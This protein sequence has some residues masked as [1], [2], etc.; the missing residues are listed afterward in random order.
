MQC[1]RSAMQCCCNALPRAAI[2]RITADFFRVMAI[3]TSPDFIDRQ[4]RV[5][6]GKLAWI[7]PISGRLM[8]VNRRGGRLCISSPDGLAMMVWLD[9][10]RLHRDDDAFCSAMQG[11]VAGLDAP[12]KLKA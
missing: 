1:W 11:V 5:Q 3:G 12:A 9:R 10:L 8:F 4:G 6:P 7:S 2:A